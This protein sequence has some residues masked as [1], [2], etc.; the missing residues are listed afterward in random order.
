M[1]G[2]PAFSVKTK[3]L[4]PLDLVNLSLPPAI[5][6][7]PRYILLMALIPDDMKHKAQKK[8]FDFFAEYEL[9]DLFHKG[10]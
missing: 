1:D 2:I 7:L 5:R 10:A 8:Y 4:K 6:A 9:N 3:S